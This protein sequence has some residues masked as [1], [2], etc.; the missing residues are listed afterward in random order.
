MAEWKAIVGIAASS[1]VCDRKPA[2]VLAQRHLEGAEHHRS[3]AGEE[4]RRAVLPLPQEQA[5]DHPDTADED[6]ELRE[7]QRMPR[8]LRSLSRGG[9]AAGAASRPARRVPRGAGTRAR[10]G[11]RLPVAAVTPIRRAIRLQDSRLRAPRRLAAPRPAGRRFRERARPPLLR[12]ATPLEA[13]PSVAAP[14]RRR[15]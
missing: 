12:F 7:R 5:D 4:R 11:G 6:Q 9:P 3:E 1:S 14:H 8:G 15:S 2:P 13:R 10:A